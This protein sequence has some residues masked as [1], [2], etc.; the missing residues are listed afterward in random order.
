MNVCTN[1]T[2][3]ATVG[4]GNLCISEDSPIAG[5]VP[6]TNYETATVVMIAFD[7]NQLKT[8]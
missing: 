3:L 8:D 2:I 1:T 5:L 6:L 4:R 7:I